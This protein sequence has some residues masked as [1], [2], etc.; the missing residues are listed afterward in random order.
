ML[1]VLLT[2]ELGLEPAPIGVLFALGGISSLVGALWAERIVRR[3]GL[4]PTMVMGLTLSSASLLCVPLAGG[5][6]PLILALVGAQQLFDA[7]ATVYEIHETS[8]I[9]V[10]TPDQLLGRVTASLRCVEWAAM[11]AGALLGGLL[12]EVIGPRATMFVGA[13]GALPAVWWLIASPV[14]QLRAMPTGR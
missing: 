14:R 3:W 7:A 11:L 4:G 1:M 13:L 12:G 2:R 8:L 5:P 9:Q 6:L 10:S